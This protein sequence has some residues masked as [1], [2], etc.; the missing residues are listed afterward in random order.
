MGVPGEIY[1]G[2]IGLAHG[3]LHHPDLTA[4]RFIPDPFSQQRGA[5]L[6]RTGDRARHRPDGTLE[7]LGRVDYQI[8]LRGFRIEPGEIEH[9][10]MQHPAVHEAV[11]VAY[12]DNSTSYLVAYVTAPDN[13]PSPSEL[14]HFL[15]M[16]LPEYM[17]PSHWVILASLPTTPNG[18]ID[19]RALPAPDRAATRHARPGVAPL[20]E[21]ERA[22]ASIW[23]E[24]L[25]I[26][27]IGTHDNFFD[28][29]GHS[30]LVIKAHQLFRDR[31]HVDLSIVELFQYPTITMLASYLNAQQ[32][33]EQAPV[34]TSDRARQQRAAINRQRQRMQN[35]SERGG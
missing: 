15:T 7:Y 22:I 6:Y 4:E 30:L 27:Q 8:K 28:L 23:Q 21:L 2:G 24:V 1:I 32:R 19:R 12:Q 35:R 14:R 33:A 34:L 5:R 3:Y 18:K 20:T 29:G 10:I 16:V 26:D 13:T 31:L 9:M 11:V 17:I 25:H